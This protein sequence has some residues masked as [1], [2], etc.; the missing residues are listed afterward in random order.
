M[1]EFDYVNQ[2]GDL[3]T[4][5]VGCWE[6][7][8]RYLIVA[9]QDGEDLTYRMDRVVQWPWRTGASCGFAFVRAQCILMR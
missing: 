1:A 2:W 4:H 3:R 9:D 8:C 6:C 7:D 5:M